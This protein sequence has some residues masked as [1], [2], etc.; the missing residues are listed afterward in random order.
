LS[1]HDTPLFNDGWSSA[2]DAAALFP[3]GKIALVYQ[4]G[5]FSCS[6]QGMGDW[7]N[8]APKR[9]G[10]AVDCSEVKVATAHCAAIFCA[11]NQP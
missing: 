8:L 5:L 9:V 7:K 6:L 3:C 2:F 10:R 11:G 1:C 4:C